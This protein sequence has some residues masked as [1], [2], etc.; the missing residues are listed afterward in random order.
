MKHRPDHVEALNNMAVIEGNRGNF[1]NAIN[2]AEKANREE[3]T[4][5]SCFNLSVWYYKTNQLEKANKYNKEALKV[6]PQ[7]A[8]SL[9]MATRLLRKLDTL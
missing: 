7:H 2:Y 1:D 8:E 9:Q 5:E 3:V 4:L 6:Y